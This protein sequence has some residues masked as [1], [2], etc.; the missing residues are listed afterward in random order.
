MPEKIEHLIK[1]LKKKLGCDVKFS[2]C[3]NTGENVK[4]QELCLKEGLGIT[5]EFTAVSAP[6]QNGKV[7][8]RRFATLHGRVRSMFNGTELSKSL[9]GG[10]W[11]ECGKTATVLDN[12]DCEEGLK[13]RHFHFWGK[14]YEGFNHLRAFGEVGIVTQGAKIRSKLD[15]KSL[16]CLHLGHAEDHGKD[17]CLF[18]KLKTTKVIRS[19]LE[20]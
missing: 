20:M 2:R 12:L 17:V 11:A 3:D 18:L 14:D 19:E 5:F 4:T 8:K 9:H 15:N 10:L 13:T 1:D 16:G 6:Q 7:F